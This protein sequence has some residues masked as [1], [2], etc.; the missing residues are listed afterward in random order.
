MKINI[1][2]DTTSADDVS[3]AA[4]L[5]RYL[6]QSNSTLQESHALMNST[7]KLEDTSAPE[8]TENTEVYVVEKAAQPGATESNVPLEDIPEIPLPPIK[9]ADVAAIPTP[10][11]D[12][13]G[14]PWDARIHA[15]TKTTI[16]NG[17]WK[18]K[19]GVSP[20]LIEQ[21]R[22][23]V[24]PAPTPLGE[25]NLEMTPASERAVP[26][27]PATVATVTPIAPTTPMELLQWI[28]KEQPSNIQQAYINAGFVD[29]NGVPLEGMQL[30]GMPQFVAPIWAAINA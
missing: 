24:A 22:S 16:S 9:P 6:A 3:R 4:E 14:Q 1:T 26:L 8:S 19:R 18:V 10:D 11:R 2:I 5:T 17:T 30:V 23:E 28:M 7:P 25:A 13:D 12:R 29:A 20:E 21:V 27:P 15:S